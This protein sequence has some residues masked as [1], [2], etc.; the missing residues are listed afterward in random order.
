MLLLGVI[1]HGNYT[2]MKMD[3]KESNIYAKIIESEL[4]FVKQK[5]FLCL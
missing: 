4:K 2:S 3:Y 1:F 5:N